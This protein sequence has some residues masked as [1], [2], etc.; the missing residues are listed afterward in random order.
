MIIHLALLLIFFLK[1]LQKKK[2]IYFFRFKF[3]FIIIRSKAE[4]Q[5]QNFD[6]PMK[7]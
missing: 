6:R 7:F 5:F 4:L 1:N 3:G 2:Y